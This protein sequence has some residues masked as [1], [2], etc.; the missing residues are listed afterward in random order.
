LLEV[1]KDAVKFRRA[2]SNISRRD[3]DEEDYICLVCTHY[4]V[5]L[6]GE[7]RRAKSMEV[8]CPGY[9]WKLYSKNFRYMQ[10]EQNKLWHIMLRIWRYWWQEAFKLQSVEELILQTIEIGVTQKRFQMCLEGRN[11]RADG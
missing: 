9:F 6:T 3:Y 5:Y 8:K 4:L 1:E 2:F 10:E 11:K 7:G